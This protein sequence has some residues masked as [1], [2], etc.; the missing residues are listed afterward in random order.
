[1]P[2]H[3]HTVR[4]QLGQS[5]YLLHYGNGIVHGLSIIIEFATGRNASRTIYLCPFFIADDSNAAFRQSP[6]KVT[7]RLVGTYRLVTVVRT[8]TMYQNNTRNPACI[9]AD[10]PLGQSQ[11]S[12]KLV[13][14]G[15]QRNIPFIHFCLIIGYRLSSANSRSRD[16][17]DCI[18]CPVSIKSH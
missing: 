16:Q 4:S 17:P 8:G 9:R 14:V 10:C 11:R 2:Q 3:I 7:E 5:P 15:S 6:S 18:Q 12:G 1:M 13:T